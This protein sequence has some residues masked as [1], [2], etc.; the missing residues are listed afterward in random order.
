[1]D[2]DSAVAYANTCMA[3]ACDTKIKFWRSLTKKTKTTTF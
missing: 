3:R 1:M 2:R